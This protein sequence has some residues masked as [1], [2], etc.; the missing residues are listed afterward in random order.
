MHPPWW[1]LEVSLW[2]AVGSCGSSHLASAHLE[3]AAKSLQIGEEMVVPNQHVWPRTHGKIPLGLSRHSQCRS[4][5]LEL[6]QRHGMMVAV[7][8]IVLWRHFCE[9]LPP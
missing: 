5:L 4:V 3:P 1:P 7:H 6:G 2:Y 8:G 9:V